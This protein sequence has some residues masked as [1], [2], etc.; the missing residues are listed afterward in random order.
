MITFYSEVTNVACECGV[1]DVVYLNF[2]KAFYTV[3]HNVIRDKLTKYRLGKYTVR[4]TENWMDV[5]AQRVVISSTK[6][7]RG[8]PL[9][10]YPRSCS[11][12]RY[13]FISLLMTWRTGQSAPSASSQLV[14]NRKEWLT[15]NGCAAI[16]SNLDVLENWANRN[17]MKVNKRKHQVL[18]LRRN[19]LRHQYMLEADWVYGS[20]EEENFGVLGNNK[21]IMRLQ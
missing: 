8:K 3:S 15:P 14:Q 1:V 10:V 4:W 13:C 19:N 9:E 20:S 17:L 16:P 6:S 21:L 5:Q 7:S 18:N 12:G 11:W 2:K